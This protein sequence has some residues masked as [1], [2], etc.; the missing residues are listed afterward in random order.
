MSLTLTNM[1]VLSSSVRI[2]YIVVIENS[3]FALYSSK[4]VDKK[5]ILRTVSNTCIY[6]SS[7]KFDTVYLV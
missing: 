4:I 2:A 3:C 5:E 6:Y 1:L 7:E